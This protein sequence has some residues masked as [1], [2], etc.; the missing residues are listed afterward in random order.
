MGTYVASKFAVEGLTATQAAELKEFNVRVNSISPGMV[1]TKSFPKAP[2][3]K[4][5]RPPDGA[6]LGIDLLLFGGGSEGVSGHYVRVDELDAVVAAGKEPE[7]AL[8][9]I[10]E[11]DF[12]P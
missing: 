3:K 11:P 7:S 4:G 12:A 1:D 10:D 2:N 8:K 5:V 9:R 6:A